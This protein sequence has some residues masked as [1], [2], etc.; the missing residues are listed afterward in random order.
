MPS[1]KITIGSKDDFDKLHKQVEEGDLDGL[2]HVTE[3]GGAPS[4]TYMY[5][6]FP[7]QATSA[8]MAGYLKQQYTMV[9]IAKNNVSPEI[10]QQLQTEIQVKQ[11]AIKDRTSSFGIAYFFTF[12][13]YMFIVAFGNTIAMNIASEKASRVM[14]VMLPSEASYDDVCEN[15]SGCFNGVIATCRI[16]VWL[17]YSIFVRLDRFRK[18]LTIWYSN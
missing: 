14:E 8:I 18:C 10:A 9:T 15:F 16:G 12:A 5:N 2:F 6:G 17:S 13:L 7:S 11:E 3:K 1:A 4:I